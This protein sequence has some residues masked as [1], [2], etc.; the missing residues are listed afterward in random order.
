VKPLDLVIPRLRSFGFN[1]ITFGFCATKMTLDQ[2]LDH[3]DCGSTRSNSG[4]WIN[5]LIGSSTIIYFASSHLLRIFSST[6]HL[7]SHLD[8]S[9]CINIYVVKVAAMILKK[10]W[11]SSD[12]VCLLYFTSSSSQSLQ[13]SLVSFFL[14]RPGPTQCLL[15]QNGGFGTLLLLQNG[16]IPSPAILCCSI[17]AMEL[18]G[19]CCS[20]LIYARA[21]GLG[22]HLDRQLQYF[23]ANGFPLGF[24]VGLRCAIISNFSLQFASQNGGFVVGFSCSSLHLGLL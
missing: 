15:H 8:P 11:L 7:Y 6:S 24:V 21:L 14:W 17:S 4:L 20:L 18:W 10:K 23:S 9:Y 12:Y 2:T 16:F 3:L 5:I 19:S 1:R 22:L 13:V